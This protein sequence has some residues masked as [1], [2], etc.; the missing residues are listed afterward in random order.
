MAVPIVEPAPRGRRIVGASRRG[1]RLDPAGRAIPDPMPR[2]ATPAPSSGP[3]RT[4]GRRGVAHAR[5]GVRGP[6]LTKGDQPW[7]PVP[8]GSACRTSA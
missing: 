7:V 1:E 2:P 4:D 6:F 8:S 5:A 3:H